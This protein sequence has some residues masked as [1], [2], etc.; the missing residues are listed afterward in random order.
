MERNGLSFTDLEI[1][2]KIEGMDHILLK[3]DKIV[4]WSRINRI[5]SSLDF[6]NI[7]HY[8]RDCYSP[9]TMYRM[10]LIQKYYSLSDRE[11]EFH[12]STNIL[13]SYF[14]KISFGNPV[15]DHTTIKRWRDRFIKHNV[16]QQLLSDFNSQLEAKGYAIRSGSIIDATFVSS[17]ARPRRKEIIDVEPTGD[18]ENHADVK[19]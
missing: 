15:P 5:L 17:Q 11:L 14:C 10:F 16:Y 9:E 13:F 12:V 8:G 2:K 3:I 19:D 18:A 4:D 1:I 7:S 6:R